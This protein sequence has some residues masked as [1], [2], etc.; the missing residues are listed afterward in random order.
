MMSSSHIPH[1][2]MSSG[3]GGH[4][5]G[6]SG[7]GSYGH[8]GG[9]GQ[10]SMG[11][12][13]G[14]APGQPTQ[15]QQQQAK[16]LNAAMLCRFGQETV[17][18]IVAR[19]QELFQLLRSTQPPDGKMNIGMDRKNKFQ[20]TLKNIKANFKRLRVIYEKIE[21]SVPSNREIPFEEDILN[22]TDDSLVLDDKRNTEAYKQAVDEYKEMMDAVVVRNRHLKDTIDH[23]RTII[24][25]VNT[26][27]SMRKE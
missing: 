25:D 5:D 1:G 8:P 24:W 23:L 10:Q 3:P 16:E 12:Q 15:Q 17:Q 13:Q 19:S 27:L 21:E 22:K 18:E 6:S 14:G 2:N 11:A 7:P 20:E 26:M 4:S 9:A